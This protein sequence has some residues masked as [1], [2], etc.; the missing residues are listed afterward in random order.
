MATGIFTL[1]NQLQGLIQKAWTGTQKTNY[2]EYLVVAGG[3]GGGS[4]NGGGGGAGGLLTGM[5]PVA[6]G[7]SYTVTVG[8]GGNGGAYISAL[9]GY[10]GLNSVFG[11][12]TAS[13]GG[14]GG[15]ESASAPASSGGS[16]GGANYAVS[17]GASAG[18]GVSG[19]GNAGGKAVASVISPYP[20]GGGGGAGTV[21]LPAVTPVAGN[22]GA[23]IA[24][25]ISGTVTTYAGGGGAG[26][27][28][29]S[30]GVAGVGGVGGG[31]A[32]STGTATNG[33]ANTGGG[34]GGSG[35]GTNSA[36]TGGSG[37]VIIS[38]PDIYAAPTFGG[39]NSPTASTSGS[40]SLS[41]NG[42]NQYI[43]TNDTTNVGSGNF[44]IEGWFYFNGLGSNQ[45]PIDAYNGSTT[46]SWQIYTNTGAHFL[47]YSA[48]TGITQIV[49][50]ATLSINTWYH[51]AAVR[52][53]T[54]VKTYV[55]GVLDGTTTDATN[56]NA[57][58]ALCIGSQRISA[59]TALLNGYASNVRIVVGTAVY[60]ANF[61]PPTAPLT[62]I[63][64][65]QYLLSA[66]SGSPL[67]DS[68]GNNYNPT[69]TTTPTWNQLS[70]FATGLGYKN[71][72]Y[73]WT[74]SGTV[75]F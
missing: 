52:S 75:T 9:P 64:G 40:G 33:T 41:F 24:S 59:P 53:G 39:A 47:W 74:A 56:Y 36:G 21:G 57:T 72:V 71:R 73:T 70:P 32:G 30:G 14:G 29:G 37:I 8:A 66:I 54:T 22:G 50:T 51:F 27:F 43:L 31:G 46:N 49:G 69:N 15:T 16:G 62:A 55:N 45:V 65:T 18:S 28:S 7:T 11:S 63:S 20:A 10:Q 42:S 61:T 44:T 2:V 23:G 3:G 60:T 35:N 26:V 48:A 58:G 4:S 68:S 34:G 12:I 25:I 19:Q 67:A 38:Y 6:T 13:G 1:R 5:V 17:S